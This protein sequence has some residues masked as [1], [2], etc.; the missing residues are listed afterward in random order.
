L[1]ADAVSA[2][3][4]RS[5]L[6]VMTFVVIVLG[7][8][9]R[10]R[11]D[12][13]DEVPQIDLAVYLRAFATLQA[14]GDPYQDRWF[15]YTPAFA[16]LGNAAYRSLGHERFLLVYRVASLLALWLLTWVS[17]R[18]VRWPAPAE[19]AAAVAILVS[20]LVGNGV[21]S[22]N[23]TVLLAGPL[24]LAL[25]I[26]ER[27]PW[28]GG[29]LAGTV[30]GWKPLGVTALCVVATPVRGRRWPARAPAIALI[31]ATAT[32]ALWLLVGFS[33]LLLGSVIALPSR[34]R[35]GAPDARR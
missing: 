5:W 16:V 10:F 9:L 24:V 15:L 19:L 12:L 8:A 23:A 14:G 18:T 30:D 7:G 21:G 31:V 11:A 22:G 1:S 27:R 34:S 25:A 26:A 29:L 13:L 3:R 35:A 33:V 32:S 2:W 4:R 6:P 20:P 17:L 28:L